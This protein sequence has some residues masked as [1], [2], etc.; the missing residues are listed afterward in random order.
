MYGDY[1]HIGAPA[2]ALGAAVEEGPRA[3]AGC[4]GVVA[5][6][7][8]L[9]ALA[10]MAGRASG[11][12]TGPTIGV[13]PVRVLESGVLDP[14]SADALGYHG[15]EAARNLRGAGPLVTTD[16]REALHVEPGAVT[17]TVAEPLLAPGAI[18]VTVVIPVDEAARVLEPMLSREVA[19][20]RR[21]VRDIGA[22]GI[23]ALRREGDQAQEWLPWFWGLGLAAVLV[24]LV[25]VW[26]S[27]SDDVR[28][29]RS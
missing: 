20:L 18:Q 16:L 3:C 6:L 19:G 26:R 15:A 23:K 24:G 10:F 27:T 9:A 4:C 13:G 5:V 2:A 14:D 25:W 28:R 1:A 12:D 17:L 7:L 11:Q 22:A 8:G 29:A 21:D